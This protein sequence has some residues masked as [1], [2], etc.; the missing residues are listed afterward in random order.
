M[1]NI[2]LDNLTEDYILENMEECTEEECWG[3]TI[4]RVTTLFGGFALGKF[5]LMIG[6]NPRS[7]KPWSI[8]GGV[9]NFKTYKN[10]TGL[11]NYIKKTNQ[12]I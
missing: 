10:F 5:N 2:T 4:H 1:I 9:G 6:H 12:Y 8:S 3:N 11:K 7:K